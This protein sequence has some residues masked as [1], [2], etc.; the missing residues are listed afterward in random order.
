MDLF[1]TLA[2]IAGAK[3]PDDRVIDGIDIQAIFSGGE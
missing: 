1:V 2:N 3:V